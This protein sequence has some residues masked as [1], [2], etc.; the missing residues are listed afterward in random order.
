MVNQANLSIFAIFLINT[1]IPGAINVFQ[2]AVWLDIQAIASYVCVCA[3][4]AVDS[5]R[6]QTDS[7]VNNLPLNFMMMLMMTI[8][9][10]KPL[11]MTSTHCFLS[12]FHFSLFTRTYVY[13]Y[14]FHKFSS[15]IWA[16]IVL[17]RFELNAFTFSRHDARFAWREIWK[18][19]AANGEKK[20]VAQWQN[21]QTTRTHDSVHI[22]KLSEWR[23]LKKKNW[24]PYTHQT[25]SNGFLSES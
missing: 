13:L 23:K 14:I 22:V 25:H 19:K 21:H 6:A 24:N 16:S 20:M 2:T 5:H 17:N 12:L 3:R 4:S 9:P 10:M 8:Q 15:Y 11:S 7:Y 1:T 18:K